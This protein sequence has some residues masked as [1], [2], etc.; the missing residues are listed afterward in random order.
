[1]L[2]PILT[3]AGEP[4]AAGWRA[5]P[6]VPALTA[7]DLAGAGAL[8]G[9]TVCAGANQTASGTG[10]RCAIRTDVAWRAIRQLTFG[11]GWSPGNSR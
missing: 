6:A 1:M 8:V 4:P 3:G 7:V 11:A 9:A 10:L 5:L 2:R